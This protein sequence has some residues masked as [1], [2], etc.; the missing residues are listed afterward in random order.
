MGIF[1]ISAGATEYIGR[2]GKPRP[3]MV[4]TAAMA[5]AALYVAAMLRA[6]IRFSRTADLGG[7][8]ISS[9]IARDRSRRKA[10]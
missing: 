7:E 9:L 6:A 5:A 2:L 3:H 8:S 10:N 1:G 4:A